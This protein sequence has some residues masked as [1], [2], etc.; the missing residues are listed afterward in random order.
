MPYNGFSPASVAPRQC[1]LY[2]ASVAGAAPFVL[3]SAPGAS[4]ARALKRSRAAQRSR[5]RLFPCA[6]PYPP[7][8]VITSAAA[9]AISFRFKRSAGLQ[10]GIGCSS[11]MRVVPS[12]RVGCR[13]L[14]FQGCGFSAP[15]LPAPDT[16]TRIGRITANVVILRAARRKPLAFA[17][18]ERRREE[19]LISQSDRRSS[20]HHVPRPPRGFAYPPSKASSV[21]RLLTLLRTLAQWNL[22]SIE[23]AVREKGLGLRF[24]ELKTVRDATDTPVIETSPI[25][26]VGG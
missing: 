22:L 25:R 4:S 11:A 21:W 15:N 20:L 8:V 12:E 26:V 17:A 18:S 9:L 1:A 16:A 3:L 24:A 23:G 6:T 14:R 7:L 2:R 13:T 10:P 5:V 19:S